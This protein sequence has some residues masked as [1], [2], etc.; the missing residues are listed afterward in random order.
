MFARK[1]PVDNP[2]LN[3]Q[4]LNLLGLIFNK[5][6]ELDQILELVW[7]KPVLVFFIEKLKKPERKAFAVVKAKR[8]VVSGVEEGAKFG[9]VIVDFFSLMG[10]IDYVSSKEGISSK[11]ILC[12]LDDSED[13][14]NKAWRRLTSV[15]F[16]SGITFVTDEKGKRTYN[17]DFKA[18]HGKLE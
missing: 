14:F 17:A 13:D 8:L 2:L 3:R 18:E 7:E 16:P 1:K 15:T 6:K 12:W 11:Y 10:E 5:T 4:I 9:G